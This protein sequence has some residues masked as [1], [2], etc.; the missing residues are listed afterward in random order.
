MEAEKVVYAV[1]LL[2]T[3][4]LSQLAL[5]VIRKYHHDKPLGMQTIHGKVTVLFLQVFASTIFVMD[6]SLAIPELWGPFP[7]NQFL[8]GGCHHQS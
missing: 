3:L 1:G 7:N 5:F 8:K 4:V 6:V 2:V